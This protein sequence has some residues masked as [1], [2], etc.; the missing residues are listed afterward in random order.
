MARPSSNGPRVITLGCR[1]NTFESE[2]MRK[3]GR[4]A[5]LDDA[6]II[7]TCAV[8]A[9]AE[10]QARQ[11]IRRVA[12][13]NPGARII[14]T[15]CAAQLD[16][17]TFAA[18]PEVSSVL[19]NEE[20]L[21]PA[22]LGGDGPAVQV[23]DIMTVR[24]LAPHLISGLEGRT[25]AFVQVQQGCD[26]RCTYC[27]IP[28]ARGPNRS[29]SVE[30]ITDQVR[31][32]VAAGYLEVV[33]TGVDICSYGADGEGS[34]GGLVGRLLAAVPE[35]KRL[36]LSTL[37][38]AAI[39]DDL[40]RLFAE[41]ERLMPHLHL[42]LQAMDDTVLKR[43]KRRHGRD[44]A[45]AV[46][47]RARKARPDAVFGADLIAGFPTETEAMFENTLAAVKDLGLAY[48]HV[49]PYSARPG[50]PAAR[51]PEVPVPVRKSRA[52]RLRAA[53]DKGLKRFLAG[54]AGT[55]AQVLVEK[56]GHGMSQGLSQHYA[57]VKLDF[58]AA[59]GTLVEAR[60]TAAGDGYLLGSRAA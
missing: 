2:V 20:K 26:H 52:A 54:R 10:R 45:F 32:L 49:F 43:M 9:E 51:M 12:R 35:L 3:L 16:P 8:T 36:R 15:G 22:R 30:A 27:I 13:D 56:A 5:G 40:F 47:A 28:F 1:L 38:P 11:T 37:D 18:M 14:V 57:T 50:T 33:L 48:L 39:D 6:I 42:S 53:G 29:L 7:N 24:E 44:D 4:D 46:V 55:T 41:E 23:A 25:R 19:G 17:E 31:T 58:D 60:V 59:P 21:D 34:L